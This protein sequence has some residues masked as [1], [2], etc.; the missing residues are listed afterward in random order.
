M[1]GFSGFTR[2]TLCPPPDWEIKGV[3][4]YDLRFAELLLQPHRITIIMLF[5]RLDQLRR[6]CHDQR[7]RAFSGARDQTSERRQLIGM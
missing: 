1:T 5:E 7:L 3:S 4:A 6:M 2:L